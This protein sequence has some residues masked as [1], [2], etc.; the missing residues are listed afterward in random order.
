ML[1]VVVTDDLLEDLDVTRTDSC[2]TANHP[3]ID[4]L[5]RERLSLGDRLVALRPQAPFAF[6]R[7]LER[8]RATAIAGAKRIRSLLRG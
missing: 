3:M 7:R 4:H 5:W 2:A 6:A 1:S 8:L